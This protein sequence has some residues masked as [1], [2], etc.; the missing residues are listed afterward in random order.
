ML[1]VFSP[2]ANVKGSDKN[3]A[4]AATD[5]EMSLLSTEYVLLRT[6]NS[7]VSAKRSVRQP[8]TSEGQRKTSGSEWVTGVK[9][10]PEIDK[11]MPDLRRGAAIYGVSGVWVHSPLLS[12]R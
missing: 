6:D 8:E 3:G 5:R 1:S 4:G 11:K 7:L 10:R 12:T 9:Y 2:G